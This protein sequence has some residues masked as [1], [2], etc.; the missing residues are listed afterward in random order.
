MTSAA[1][2]ARIPRAEQCLHPLKS[3]HA[4]DACKRKN[5]KEKN[6]EICHIL[7]RTKEKEKKEI[8]KTS[9]YPNS[10]QHKQHTHT[11][12]VHRVSRLFSHTHFVA[13]S[14]CLRFFWGK[15]RVHKPNREHK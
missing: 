9:W 12:I 5:R 14:Y 15:K 10:S 7:T 8:H 2:K 11:T 6:P 4:M 3:H 13:S 1:T